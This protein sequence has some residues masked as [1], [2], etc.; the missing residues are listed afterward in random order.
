M[1]RAEG[2]KFEAEGGEWEGFLGRDNEPPSPPH[3]L[4]VWGSA[5]SSPSGVLGRAVTANAFWTY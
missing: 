5:V 4:E 2:P 1:L 3:Q